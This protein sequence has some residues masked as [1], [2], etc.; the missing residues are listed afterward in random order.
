MMPRKKSAKRAS[1]TK[2]SSSSDASPAF[3]EPSMHALKK[4]EENFNSPSELDEGTYAVRG[5]R[6]KQ[7]GRQMSFRNLKY[8]ERRP[9]RKSS[10]SSSKTRK[11]SSD[12]VVA[13]DDTLAHQTYLEDSDPSS[14]SSA[15]S[16]TNIHVLSSDSAASKLE[17]YASLVQPGNDLTTG[18]IFCVESS[19]S[20][21]EGELGLSKNGD[22]ASVRQQPV[23]AGADAVPKPS[24]EKEIHRSH[25]G[26]TEQGNHANALEDMLAMTNPVAVQ[27]LQFKNDRENIIEG[28][29]FSSIP[30]SDASAPEVDEGRVKSSSIIAVN[31]THNVEFMKGAAVIEK[32]T[33]EKSSPTMGPKL[34][35]RN[36]NKSNSKRTGKRKEGDDIARNVENPELC[37]TFA[38]GQRL[39][40]VENRSQKPS[41]VLQKMNHE[42]HECHE[43]KAKDEDAGS[44]DEKFVDEV[45]SS[46][47][48]TPAA[49][50]PRRKL[51]GRSK[52]LSR[53]S[54]NGVWVH[55]GRRTKSL[56]SSMDEKEPVPM[57]QP[58]IRS[59]RLL[60]SRLSEP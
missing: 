12:T 41:S 25:C 53:R 52:S 60:H 1:S 15:T 46:G 40:D 7:T 8:N 5:S 10:R 11:D 17:G 13:S 19:A 47:S 34:K 32:G 57:F 37:T 38:Y 31:L 6:L 27:L 55:T 39:D 29:S 9:S 45:Q 16:K 18:D 58:E 14:G 35:Q 44:V 42:D 4:N 23:C 24:S 51:A 56:G 59:L 21:G 36:R 2:S 30:P 22:V 20:V 33:K 50:I 48:N 54:H 26:I 28:T 43:A 3:S 49:S